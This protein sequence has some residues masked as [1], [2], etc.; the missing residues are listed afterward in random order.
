MDTDKVNYDVLTDFGAYLFSIT[1]THIKFAMI[2][3]NESRIRRLLHG[4][5]QHFHK[6]IKR[7]MNF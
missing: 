7:E 2:L 4:F 3:L 5:D 6:S 1:N